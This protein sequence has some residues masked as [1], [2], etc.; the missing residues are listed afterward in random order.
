[1][2]SLADQFLGGTT[3][4]AA[5]P[6]VAQPSLVDQFLSSPKAMVQTQ[7]ITPE[8]ERIIAPPISGRTEE[9]S[10]QFLR[11][12]RQPQPPP[13]SALGSA[14][15]TYGKDVAKNYQANVDYAR[16]GLEESVSNRPLGIGKTILGGL[17]A[18]ISPITTAIE[19]GFVKPIN[20]LI[21]G[22]PN[23]TSLPTDIMGNPTSDKPFKT[24]TPAE[25]AI[26]G[27]PVA[28]GIKA[29]AATMPSSKAVTAILDT[30][31]KENLPAVIAE[32]KSNPR[33]SL[34]DVVPATR[35]MAQKLITNEGPHQN[36]FEKFVTD[37]VATGRDATTDIYN[38]GMGVPVDIVQ[39]INELK[40][41]AKD[42]GKSQIQPAIEGSKPV[43]I[44]AV[45]KS[46]DD[47][48]KPG[49]NSII[50]TGEA[51]PLGDIEKPLAAV[52]KFLTDDKSVRSDPKSLHQFQS[53][54]RATAEDMLN[55]T[56]GITRQKGYA[57]MGVRNDIVNA[58]D[59]A[60]GG[61]YKEALSAF[62]DEK[63]VENAFNMGQ[64][65][66]RNKLGR[67]EDSPEFWNNW[68][69]SATPQELAAAKEGA[70]LAVQHQI[71]G[72]KAGAR[73]GQDIVESEF[74][75]EKLSALFGKDE[76]DKMAKTLKD[77]RNI[78]ITNQQLIG[79]SQTAMR[80]KADSRVDLP[81]R[82]GSSIT[83]L[84]APVMELAALTTTG[85]PA[86][87]S[88]LV[89][90]AK[91]L[92]ALKFKADTALAKSRNIKITDYLTAT[93]ED[94]DAL[95]KILES[96]LPQPKQSLLQRTQGYALP[97]LPP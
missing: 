46:I 78:A 14:V 60:S 53:A 67:L 17:G 64:L 73:K 71:G 18:V 23:T 8:S 50:T 56:D 55:S 95:I 88:G 36:K 82:G 72:F 19:E 33:L 11:E 37:R 26:S 7:T 3:T 10:Q 87:G 93:G 22:S 75:K 44:S 40:Q 4:P 89:L 90:G 32:L 54:I 58:I 66:T 68:V 77:E 12:A 65:V 51:L 21:P 96:H 13:Q 79:N 43:D 61:K 85:I 70:R 59:N 76:I 94:R 29:V 35:Q 2:P 24:G 80:M 1:M 83:T 48:L 52:R 15:E 84:A 42:V 57:L 91:G 45:I 47:K 74:N 49:V 92:G 5:T 97:V 9:Q 62:R 27:L 63:Q 38:S 20:K 86:L 28:R 30:V 25:I 81:V 69:K 31:G 39:K 6:E 16:T 34:M 41:N